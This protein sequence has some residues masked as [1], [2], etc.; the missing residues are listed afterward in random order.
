MYMYVCIYY[1][2]IYLTNNKIFPL[3]IIEIYIKG[4]ENLFSRKVSNLF[5]IKY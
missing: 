5:I 2:Y 4:N 3:L 1:A